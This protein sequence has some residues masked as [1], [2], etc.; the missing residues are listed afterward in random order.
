MNDAQGWLWH[1]KVWIRVSWRAF[2][3]LDAWYWFL[4][5]RGFPISGVKS[6][7]WLWLLSESYLYNDLRRG[8][9]PE[10]VRAKGVWK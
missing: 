10:N 5:H 2:Q 6:R 1:E 4:Y 8:D 9:M 3:A 7:L